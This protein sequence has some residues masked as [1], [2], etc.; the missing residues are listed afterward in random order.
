MILLQGLHCMLG[1]FVHIEKSNANSP[2]RHPADFFHCRGHS[3]DG[4]MF[5]QIMD[6]K[7]IKRLIRRIN[8]E[9]IPNLKAY[10]RKQSSRIFDI[11]LAEVESAVVNVPADS[12]RLQEAVIV[13]RTTR[14]FND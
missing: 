12:E 11:F 8:V 7:K 1:H 10:A 3:F 4:K 2:A 9:S 5:K 6:I 14:G 13:G